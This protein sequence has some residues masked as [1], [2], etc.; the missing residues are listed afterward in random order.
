MYYIPYYFNERLYLLPIDIGEPNVLRVRFVHHR[1]R[2]IKFY[3]CIQVK[4]KHLKIV[5]IYIKHDL[6]CI[7]ICL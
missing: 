7:A 5:L 4:A 3:S 1:K 6:T 2:I